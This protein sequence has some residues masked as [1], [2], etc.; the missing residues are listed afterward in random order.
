MIKRYWYSVLTTVTC[1]AAVTQ[2]HM[3]SNRHFD[4]EP[5]GKA[6]DAFAQLSHRKKVQ[7]HPDNLHH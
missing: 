6:G 4:R 5:T 2:L 7:H 1:G 3:S